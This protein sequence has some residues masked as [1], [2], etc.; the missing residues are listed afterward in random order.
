LRFDAKLIDHYSCKNWTVDIKNKTQIADLVKQHL[1]E[2]KGKGKHMKYLRCDNAPEHSAKLANICKEHGVHIEF[3]A[4]YMLQQNGIVERKIVMDCNCAMAMLLGMWLTKGAQALLCAK[5][6]STA[7]RLSNMIWNKQV[8]GI[9]NVIFNGNSG[10]LWPKLLI[11]FGCIGYIQIKCQVN[12]K[13][14]EKSTKCIMVGYTDNH[15]ADT[16]RMYDPQTNTVH[17][18][19]DVRWAD[20]HC[21]DPATTLDIFQCDELTKHTSPVGTAE[22]NEPQS[23]T[24]S[25]LKDTGPI[26]SLLS[27]MKWEGMI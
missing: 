6:E 24:L 23:S 5:A 8:Q 1:D 13:W 27:S 2:L 20:W 17:L 3:M 12:T 22:D 11:K 14:V 10:K 25:I 9:P 26:L 15:S 16:Y 19:H 21:T 4:P 18:T 7:T